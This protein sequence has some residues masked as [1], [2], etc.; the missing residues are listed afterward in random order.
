[1]PKRYPEEYKQRIM[2]DYQ[3]G[4]PI[5]EIGRTNNV[6]IS[7][8]YRW[9]KDYAD[10]IPAPHYATLARKKE[11]LEHVLKVICL[12]SLIDE[13]PLRKRLDILETLHTRHEEYNVHELCEALNVA[14][15]TF[16]NHIIHRADRSKYEEEQ[17]QLM[18]QVNQIFDE[19]Q[20]RFGA[21]KIRIILAENGV[22]VGKKRI[23]GIIQELGLES[24]RENAKK[25][26]WP[27]ISRPVA[28]M[29]S[30]LVT[31]H[32]LKLKIIVSIS[33]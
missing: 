8:I 13:V 4:V 20:Q 1:M 9:L 7:T 29:K 2:Q 10:E 19:S 30:G 6:A 3:N 18:L 22:H 24:I 5:Q 26:Y 23:R 17:S 21:E 28:K 32:I 25:D 27:K 16:Y 14:R 33:A 31:L 11:Y 15:G 12:S